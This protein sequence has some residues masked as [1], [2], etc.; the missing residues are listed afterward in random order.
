MTTV[1][2]RIRTWTL[3]LSVSILFILAVNLVLPF[4]PAHLAA[5]ARLAPFLNWVNIGNRAPQLA[6]D[7]PC[8]RLPVHGGRRGHLDP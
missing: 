2:L 1:A 3:A 8:R 4:V 5:N 7:G 6:L